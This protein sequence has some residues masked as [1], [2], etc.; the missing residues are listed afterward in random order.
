M[1]ACAEKS[2]AYRLAVGASLAIGGS[3]V[4]YFVYL[5]ATSITRQSVY[6]GAIT[7]YAALLLAVTALAL[8]L[9]IFSVAHLA[10]TGN[11]KARP[12]A[13]WGA[14]SLLM[15]LAIFAITRH[16]INAAS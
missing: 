10:R 8:S 4:L 12:A 14:G 2:V 9:L 6:M 15:A 16:L 1:Q 5:S 7:F 13:L 3:W 11:R